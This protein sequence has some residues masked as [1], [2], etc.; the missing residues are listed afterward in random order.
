M[1]P[2]KQGKLPAVPKAPA[3]SSGS[4][5]T[6]GPTLMDKA[7][8][9]EVGP[10]PKKPRTA[11]SDDDLQGMVAKAIRDN[12]RSMSDFQVDGMLVEGLTLRARLEQ[13]KQ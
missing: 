4:A 11:R 10:S 1:A 5:S 8:A 9:K 12:F 7:A 3:S 13:D 2:P 6:D